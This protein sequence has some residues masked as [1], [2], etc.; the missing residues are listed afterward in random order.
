LL[1]KSAYLCGKR[2]KNPKKPNENNF[3]KKGLG[4]SDTAPQISGL[5]YIAECALP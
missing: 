1:K 3:S 4:K 5:R 2:L